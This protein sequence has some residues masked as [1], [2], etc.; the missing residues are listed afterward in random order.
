MEAASATVTVTVAPGP[1]APSGK[2][3]AGGASIP[4][5][6]DSW[7]QRR[8]LISLQVDIGMWSSWYSFSVILVQLQEL[9]S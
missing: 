8:G 7:I 6:F 4:T 1:A 3:S 2:S 9:R 5:I